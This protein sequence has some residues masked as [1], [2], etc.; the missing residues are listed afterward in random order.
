MDTFTNSFNKAENNQIVYMDTVNRV[1]IDLN[2]YMCKHV[3]Q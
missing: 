1:N 3:V 2:P